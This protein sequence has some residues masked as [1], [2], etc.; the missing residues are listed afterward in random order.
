[1]IGLDTSNNRKSSRN[2]L[3]L[4]FSAAGVQSCLPS[5]RSYSAKLSIRRLWKAGRNSSAIANGVCWFHRSRR[6][7]TPVRPE[8]LQTYI[9]LFGLANPIEPHRRIAD[10]GCGLRRRG[11]LG[12]CPEQRSFGWFQHPPCIEFD[13]DGKHVV[14]LQQI[15]NLPH[16]VQQ[17]PGQVEWIRPQ[18]GIDTEHPVRGRGTLLVVHHKAQRLPIRQCASSPLHRARPP[19]AC[20]SGSN[21]QLKRISSAAALKAAA[22]PR[23][24]T[25][26]RRTTIA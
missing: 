1:M 25:L 15:G 6:S 3:A 12:D 26:T 13:D 7:S 16:R 2:T 18:A 4:A 17:Q 23:P 24:A 22:S 14:V 19:D 9:G 10:G 20:S 8:L 21:R 11:R 5:R